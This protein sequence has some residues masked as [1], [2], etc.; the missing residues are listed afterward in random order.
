[1]PDI[2]DFTPNQHRFFAHYVVYLMEQITAKPEAYTYG[3]NQAS[4][5]A[6]KMVRALTLGNGNKDSAAIKKTCQNI[7]I[8]YRYRDIH[9]Y[10]NEKTAR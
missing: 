3:I 10:L 5:V 9:A 6:A 2:N 7:G 4:E 1:M 8:A